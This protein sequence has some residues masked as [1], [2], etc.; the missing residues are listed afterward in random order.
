MYI[1]KTREKLDE[2]YNDP[3]NKIKIGKG[4]ILEPNVI[5]YPDVDIGSDCI[6]GTSAVIKPHTTIGDH[7]I[8]GTLSLS[9]GN[10][11]IGNWTTIYAQC[12]LTDGITIGDNCFIGAFFVNSNTANIG[13][14]HAKF[15]YPNSTN[16]PRVNTII[17]DNVKIGI[18]VTTIPGIVIEKYA[19]IDAGSF[20][21]KRVPQGAHIRSVNIAAIDLDNTANEK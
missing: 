7:S 12:H 9:E 10:V 14:K 21:T 5:I 16:M 11:K 20:I 2:I 4:T 13:E 19:V 8:F 1:S 6:I 18:R 17:E 15:G 3:K